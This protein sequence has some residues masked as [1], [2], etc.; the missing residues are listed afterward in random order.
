M[1]KID[2][3]SVM[4][5]PV[6]LQVGGGSGSAWEGAGLLD[7]LWLLRWGTQPVAGGVPGGQP[8]LEILGP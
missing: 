3:G 2:P 6:K 1:L 7:V 5:T 4:P 8:S